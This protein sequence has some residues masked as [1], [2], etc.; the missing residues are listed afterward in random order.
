MWVSRM[1]L[2]SSF[3]FPVSG[4]ILPDRSEYLVLDCQS[5]ILLV[6]LLLLLLLVLPADVLVKHCR[7]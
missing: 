4:G 5:I 6:L 7:Y 2:I 1:E 3:F